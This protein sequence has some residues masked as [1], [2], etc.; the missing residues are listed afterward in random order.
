MVRPSILVAGPFLPNKK[1][2]IRIQNFIRNFVILQR[3]LPH[4][5]LFLV[6]PGA[7]HCFGDLELPFIIL[8]DKGQEIESYVFYSNLLLLFETTSSLQKAALAQ[9]KK[10]KSPV[11]KFSLLDR[12]RSPKVLFESIAQ[13]AVQA[14]NTLATRI[15]CYTN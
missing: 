12:I 15:K 8:E 5:H 9:A 13:S 14:D 2:T 10:I 3:T 6:G 11:I 1:T 7:S 4:M